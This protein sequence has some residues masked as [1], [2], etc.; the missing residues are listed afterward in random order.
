[1]SGSVDGRSPRTDARDRP[2]T[3]DAID[4]SNAGWSVLTEL[5]QRIRN[6]VIAL[7]MQSAADPIRSRTS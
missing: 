5:G 4:K 6:S 7:Q 2:I 1:M 3:T